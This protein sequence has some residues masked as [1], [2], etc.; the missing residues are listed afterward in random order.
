M[1]VDTLLG[2]HQISAPIT[3]TGFSAAFDGNTGTLL[4]VSGNITGTGQLVVNGGAVLLTGANNFLLGSNGSRTII[5]TGGNLQIASQGAL[6][7]NSNLFISD[8]SSATV[9]N[10]GAGPSIVLQLNTLSLGNNGNGQLDLSNN[11]MIVHNGDLPTLTGQLH[12]GFNNGAWT[13]PGI[14][15]S[16]AT[17]STALAIELNSDG[18]G[19]TLMSTFDSQPVTNTDVLVKYTYFGDTDLSGTVNAADYVSTDNGFNSQTGPTPALRLDP[20]RFQLRRKYQRRRLH[21]DR[22]RLQHPRLGQFRQCFS[23]PR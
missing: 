13:G 7:P 20:R 11:D 14:I 9:E 12:Q 22:Q 3:L 15:T 19:G 8:G 4:T 23:R 21:P 5:N 18:H 17:N 6:Q 10:H 16:A 1:E 2:N